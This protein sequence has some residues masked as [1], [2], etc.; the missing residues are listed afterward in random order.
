MRKLGLNVLDLFGIHSEALTFQEYRYLNFHS[1]DSISKEHIQHFTFI[2]DPN[3]F[4]PKS[5]LSVI[6]SPL[7]PTSVH[8]I[9]NL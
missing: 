4:H 9:K 1:T 7:L 5:N 2:L 6:Y 3:K 8:T